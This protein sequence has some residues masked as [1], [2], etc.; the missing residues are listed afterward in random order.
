M[1]VRENSYLSYY[2]L[3][4]DCKLNLRPVTGEKSLASAFRL[5]WEWAQTF[6]RQHEPK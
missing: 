3:F 1:T 6:I 2:H 4:L 5:C